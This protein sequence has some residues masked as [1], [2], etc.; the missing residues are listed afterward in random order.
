MELWQLDIVD[1]IRLADGSE[2]KI[3][4][5]VDDHSR[6]C[7]IPT[8]VHRA[9]GRAVCTAFA[10]RVAGHRDRAGRDRRLPHRPPAL[11]S[12]VDRAHPPGTMTRRTA[13]SRPIR[14]SV[15]SLA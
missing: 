4:T 5:G 8:V 9:T 15:E 14:P 7:V 1:G 11:E 6:F 12:R 10:K 13:S 2:T 3:V